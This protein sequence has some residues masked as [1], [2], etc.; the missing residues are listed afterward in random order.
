MSVEKLVRDFDE[1]G[2][3]NVLR[4]HSAYILRREIEPAP[5]Q[6]MRTRT[7]QKKNKEELRPK[8]NQ[9]RQSKRPE[10]SPEEAVESSSEEENL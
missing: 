6:P 2:L 4:S 5:A 8:K 3:E 10:M 7:G 9:D 1:R